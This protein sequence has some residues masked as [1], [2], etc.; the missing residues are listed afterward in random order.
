MSGELAAFATDRTPLLRRSS[1][2]STA[3]S[4]KSPR[5]PPDEDGNSDDEAPIRISYSRGAVI[6][7]S[8]GMLIFLQGNYF[9]LCADATDVDTNQRPIF[10]C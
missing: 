10:R 3:S 6:G 4:T 7:F 2:S 5:S 8:I 1:L 9:P